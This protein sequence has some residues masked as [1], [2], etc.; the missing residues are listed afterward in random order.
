MLESVLVS[1]L[2]G[3][4]TFEAPNTILAETK[5]AAITVAYITFDSLIKTEK[6]VVKWDNLSKNISFN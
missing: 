4:T 2:I 6:V 1:K 5:G 3:N